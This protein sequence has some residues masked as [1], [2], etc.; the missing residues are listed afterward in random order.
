MQARAELVPLCLK[1]MG[2]DLVEASPDDLTLLHDDAADLVVTASRESAPLLC[3]A[4]V[5]VVP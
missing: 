5:A 4:E 3:H 1:G 2:L